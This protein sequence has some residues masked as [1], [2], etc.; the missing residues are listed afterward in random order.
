[1]DCFSNLSFLKDNVTLIP[2][3]ILWTVLKGSRIDDQRCSMPQLPTKD[4]LT[5][6][7]KIKPL[8][9]SSSTR[10]ASFSPSSNIERPKSKNKTPPKEVSVLYN[11]YWSKPFF[12]VNKMYCNRDI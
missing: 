7:E 5:S 3:P 10:S 2:K 8:S 12:F 6:P 11:C 9:D 4:T 1:M